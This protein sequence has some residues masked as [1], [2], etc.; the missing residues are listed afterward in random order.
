MQRKHDPAATPKDGRAARAVGTRA[1]LLEQGRRLFGERGYEATP[2]GEVCAAANATTGALYHHFRDKKGLFAAVAEMLDAQLVQVA[3][4]ATRRHALW[5]Q[6]RGGL[7]RQCRAGRDRVN[8]G[9]V[10]SLLDHGAQVFDFALDRVRL[11]VAALSAS[12]PV[13][14]VDRELLAELTGERL[15]AVTLRQ[16]TSHDDERRSLADFLIRDLSSVFRRGKSG[17]WGHLG[18]GACRHDVSSVRCGLVR[19]CACRR[20]RQR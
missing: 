5:A 7:Q 14:H 11:G 4:A 12:S 2:L 1:G 16:G 17:A 19:C 18:L 8:V 6:L 3:Q 10:A 20:A 13:I 9:V 15:A